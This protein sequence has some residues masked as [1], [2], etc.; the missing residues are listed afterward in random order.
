MAWSVEQLKIYQMAEALELQ[1]HEFTK[2]FPADERFRSVDQ[3]R[4]SSS[5]PTNNIAEMYNKR[6]L[7]ERVRIL[8]D[9]CRG[10][11]D[12]TR[13]NLVRCAKKGFCSVEVAQVLASK[14]TELAKAIDGFIQYLYRKAKHN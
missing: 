1:V 2:S 11:I 3:L 12:E 14:Y 6:S 4:R 7:R 5:S 8:H 13:T 10:E 9:I